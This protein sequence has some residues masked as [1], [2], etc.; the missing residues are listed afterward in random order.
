MFFPSSAHFFAVVFYRMKSIGWPCLADAGCAKC[1]PIRIA[2]FANAVLLYYRNSYTI[3]SICARFFVFIR[4]FEVS[5]SFFFLA[6]AHFTFLHLEKRSEVNGL[7]QIKN[8]REKSIIFICSNRVPSRV[9]WVFL[10]LF[11]ACCCSVR[12]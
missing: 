5:F 4:M 8:T 12:F 3:Y 6:G 2:L 7:W 10:F 9:P 1:M 11:G